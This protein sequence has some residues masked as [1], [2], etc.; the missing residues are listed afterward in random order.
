MVQETN[1]APTRWL[2]ED[3]FTSPGQGGLE[4]GLTSGMSAQQD[5]K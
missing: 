1:T 5:S 2:G 4:A 3:Y